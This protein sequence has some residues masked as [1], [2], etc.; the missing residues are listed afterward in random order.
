MYT[1]LYAKP[2]LQGSSRIDRKGGKGRAE[3]PNSAKRGWASE[4]GIPLEIVFMRECAV[5][6]TS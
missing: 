1:P 2:L 4:L 3:A 6:D 5:P